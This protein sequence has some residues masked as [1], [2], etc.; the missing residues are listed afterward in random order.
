MKQKQ[1]LWSSL[2]HCDDYEDFFYLR[3]L[4]DISLERPIIAIADL[5]LWNGRH[6]GYKIIGDNVQ[7]CFNFGR[8]S[9]DM[10]WFLDSHDLRSNQFHHDG[11][12]H[13]VYRVLREGRRLNTIKDKIYFGKMTNRDLH[14]YTQSIKPF[15]V[16]AWEG[17]KL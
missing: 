11:T 12:N 1:I 3:G 2:E 16:R 15:V 9:D 10:E 7:S 5:G 14:N 6:M 4:M 8:D 17:E 13:I